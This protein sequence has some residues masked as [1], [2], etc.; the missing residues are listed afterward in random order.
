MLL[1]SACSS[2]KETNNTDKVVVEKPKQEQKEEVTEEEKEEEEKEEEFKYVY[3]FTGVGIHEESL[4]RPI[5]VMI[6]NHPAARPQ[7]GL[8][9]ADI[10]FEVLAE[11]D[12]T[13]FLAVFQSES[14]KIIGPV[15][16]ARD[17]YIDLSQGLDAFYVAHGWS[18]EAQSILSSGKVDNLNG[19]FYDGSLFWRAKH[20][21]APHNSYTSIENI[22]K[23]ADKKGYNMELSNKPYAFLTDKEAEVIEGLDAKKVKVSYSSRSTFTNEYV[24]NSEKKKYE[25]FSNNEQTIDR[26]TEEP[27]LLDNIL[28]VEMKH[29]VIDSY[30]RREVNLT[31][32][33]NGYLLQRGKAIEIEW[34]NVDGR[35]LPFKDGQ[36]L[37]F[38]QGK[39]WVSIIPTSPGLSGSVSFGK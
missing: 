22:E 31:S 7:S 1:I 21:K 30:G 13:R 37:G 26:E 11:G 12:V 19:L 34:K 2:A 20:R 14:P 38:V 10:V 17:Y 15:R 35:F 39:T 9:K 18:P 5:A 36:E 27:V 28:I 33:G 29:K 25:R 23:G 6:N 32:G 3:P 8:H 24:Y 16:S 4:Q